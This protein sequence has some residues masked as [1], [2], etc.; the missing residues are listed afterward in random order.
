MWTLQKLQQGREKSLHRDTIA[1]QLA[2]GGRVRAA[3]FP[4]T[5]VERPLLC[6]LQ[7]TMYC[8][9]RAEPPSWQ[10]GSCLLQTGKR[11]GKSR[12]TE[13]QWE[14]AQKAV[15]TVTLGAFLWHTCSLDHPSKGGAEL[16]PTHDLIRKQSIQTISDLEIRDFPHGGP[17][18]IQFF[19]ESS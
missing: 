17:L 9:N 8:R 6:E 13:K 7:C 12:H 10:R 16:R 2:R 18:V 14:K 5:I 11:L 3:V 4:C 19:C 15:S 1:S